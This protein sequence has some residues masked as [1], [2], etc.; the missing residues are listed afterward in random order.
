VPKRPSWRAS[1][2]PCCGCLLGFSLFV[3]EA[4]CCFPHERPSRFV[5]VGAYSITPATAHKIGLAEE[6]LPKLHN[7]IWGARNLTPHKIVIGSV[8]PGFATAFTELELRFVPLV[9]PDTRLVGVSLPQNLGPP[10][11][12]TDGWFMHVQFL[13]Y[14]QVILII[15]FGLLLPVAA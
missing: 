14:I 15:S 9:L 1:P 10:L 12:A 3:I 6:L 2:P 13:K 4:D 5:P 11:D 8:A 7:S